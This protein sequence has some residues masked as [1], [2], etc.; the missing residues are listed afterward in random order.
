MFGGIGGVIIGSIVALYIHFSSKPKKNGL[1]Y[2]LLKK[3]Q[4]LL[5]I[6]EAEYYFTKTA[7]ENYQV[8]RL[9][10]S[11]ADAEI[12]A[13]AFN[14]NPET[15][16]ESDLARGYR[17]G[18]LFT[19]IT[20]EDIC[21]SQS[22]THCRAIMD[23]ILRGSNLIVVPSG[24]AITKIDGI[25]CRFK[26]DTHLCAIS[27]RDPQNIEKNKGVVFRDGI[28][29]GFFAYYKSITEKYC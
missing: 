24:E 7:N 19:R 14:E 18:S 23:K 1:A 26:D 29:E 13:T 5:K 4:F 21:P 12:I 15:Y 16:G 6:S 11:D 22:V 10:Y 3:L 28:A 25:F 17:Y 27:F 9:I 2:A 8:A 20:C